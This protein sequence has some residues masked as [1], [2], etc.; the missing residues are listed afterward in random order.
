MPIM[1]Y[2]DDGND[3]QRHR[4]A[5]R[6]VTLGTGQV[7]TYTD[8]ALTTGSTPRRLPAAIGG[9]LQ[10]VLTMRDLADAE[11]WR[12]PCAGHSRADRRRRLYRA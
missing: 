1:T 12:P 7:L 10:G 8:L 2:P 6:T 11:G 9:D 5:A 3:R 4:S